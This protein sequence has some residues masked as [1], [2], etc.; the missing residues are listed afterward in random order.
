MSTSSP[1]VARRSPAKSAGTP[2]RGNATEPE[3]N[4]PQTDAVAV[5]YLRTTPASF[6]TR[7]A[8]PMFD[9]A[10]TAAWRWMVANREWLFSGVGVLVLVEL[11]RRLRH[12]MTGTRQRDSDVADRRRHSKATSQTS[13]HWQ[14]ISPPDSR[15]ERVTEIADSIPAGLQTVALEYGPRGHAYP[16]NLK[17]TRARAEIQF[18]CRVHDVYKVMFAANEYAMNVLPPRFMVG[19]RSILEEHSLKTLRSQRKAIATE[20]MT[21]LA[22]TFEELGMTLESVE[23]GAI[24]NVSRRSAAR[25]RLT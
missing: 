5:R 7:Y 3:S 1:P 4:R 8:M 9:E 12:L 17:G 13:D 18:S 6:V 14:G 15:F 11:G 25:S 20:I 21:Q 24:E 22:P 10:V 19:A 23:L 16:L 2:G